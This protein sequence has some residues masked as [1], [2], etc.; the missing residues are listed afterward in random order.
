M[1]LSIKTASTT[2][3]VAGKTYTLLMNAHQKRQ[4]RRLEEF[5]QY[6]E[7]NYERMTQ[8]DKQKI[9]Q[10]IES[11]EGEE[12]LADY[13]ES[14]LK[15]SSSRVIMAMALLFF[16]E[17]EFANK[18]KINFIKAA[19]NLNDELVDFYLITHNQEKLNDDTMPY[20][21]CG[22][23]AKDCVTHSKKGW[24]EETIAIY[25]D[26]LIKLRLLLLD[27]QTQAVYGDGSWS[28]HY[29]ISNK[30]QKIVNLLMKAEALL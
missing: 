26:E 9:N 23:S 3:K 21:R 22:F 12:L 7:T 29:G 14:I 24:N 5:S 8:E 13:A 16:N 20:I 17:K 2:L 30:T 11:N 28:I 15:V 10:F 19:K 18:E 1:E 27:P 4:K 6:F 25:I